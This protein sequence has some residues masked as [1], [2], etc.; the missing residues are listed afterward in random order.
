MSIR[1]KQTAKLLTRILIAAILLIWVFSQVDLAQFFQTVK[2]AKWQYLAA[3]W[4][5]TLLFFWIRSITLQLLLRK[6]DC[7]VDMV[8][9][10]GASAITSL[11]SMVMPGLLSTGVK[12]YILKKD[13]GKGTNVLSSMLYNEVSIVVAMIV[14]GLAALIAA[15]PVSILWP[16]TSQSWLLP[17]LCG[18]SLAL[19]VLVSVLLLNARTGKPLITVLRLLSK[20]LP[21]SLQQHSAKILS[22]IAQFQTVGAWFHLA[23][24]ATNV[25]ACIV[26][27]VLIYVAAAKSAGITVPVGTLIWLCAAVFVLGRLPISVA[28]LGVRE[29]TLTGLLSIYGVEKASA[30]LMSMVLFSSLIFMAVIGAAFQ[31]L[32]GVDSKNSEVPMNKRIPRA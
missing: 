31:V 23:I 20:P 17:G 15:N 18:A 30:L 7:S 25:I 22:Q 9:L 32:W 29:M 19:V 2:T 12:W 6:L 8:T 14:F 4:L 5:F 1:G 24:A 13:T 16:E 3:V 27:G 26:G 28:N 21:S 11:Y 10:F